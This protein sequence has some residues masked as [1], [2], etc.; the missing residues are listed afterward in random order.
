[1][2]FIYKIH[3]G[4]DGF[5]PKR[6]SER[7]VDGKFLRLGWKRYLDEVDKGDEVWVYFHG[8]HNFQ[9]GVYAKGRVASKDVDKE[10]LLL[11]VYKY[12][13]SS[14]ITD[15]ITSTRI[16]SIVATRYRQ[17]FLLPADWETVS[18][19]NAFF[20]ARSCGQRRCEWCPVWKSLPL[21]RQ[22]EIAWPPRLPSRLESFVSSYWVIPPRCFLS[23]SSIKVP[24]HQTTELLK[25]FKIG[26]KHLG[27]PFALAIFEALNRFDPTLVFD[28]IVPIPLSPDKAKSGEIHRTGLLAHELSLLMEIP[29]REA[30]F[31]NGPVSKRRMLSAGYTYAQFQRAYSDLLGVTDSVQD[32]TRVLLLDDVSTT[33]GTLAMACEA[34]WNV[35]PQVEIVAVTAAQMILKAVVRHVDHLLTR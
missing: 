33:G 9:D 29:V 6:I 5:Q 20:S 15:Q 19:C 34:I 18:D 23:V 2:K 10:E 13:F 22:P 25:S 24:F 16:A 32:L 3:S 27:Y 7:L 26:N 17:V 28:A 1:M 14:P 31:L 35:N 11:R 30:L 12:R 8:P 4:Y 21:I